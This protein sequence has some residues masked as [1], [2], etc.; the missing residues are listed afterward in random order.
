M[1][2]DL[3]KMVVGHQVVAQVELQQRLYGLVVVLLVI[4]AHI[5]QAVQVLVTLL[6]VAVVVLV[7]VEEVNKINADMAELV[8]AL[9]L[10]TNVRKDVWVRV[11]LSA[12][13]VAPS[14]ESQGASLVQQSRLTGTYGNLA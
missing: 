11:P 12:Q 2:I 9:V 10:E 8:D 5:T 7:A 1:T 14:D 13:V 6:A 4:A 3:T